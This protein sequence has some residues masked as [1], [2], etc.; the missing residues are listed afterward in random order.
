MYDIVYVCIQWAKYIASI[1]NNIGLMP[2]SVPRDTF[3]E[4]G[5]PQAPT[6]NGYDFL[7]LFIE[8]AKLMKEKSPKDTKKT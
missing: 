6:S 8:I 4:D 7:N 5:D 1:Y 2:K 3:F